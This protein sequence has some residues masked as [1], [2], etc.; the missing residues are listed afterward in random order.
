MIDSVP[1]PESP[2]SGLMIDT[3]PLPESP[4]SGL[5]IGTG[6]DQQKKGTTI[7]ISTVPLPER[8]ILP[9]VY[10]IS[11]LLSRELV[12]KLTDGMPRFKYVEGIRGGI[13]TAHLHLKDEVVLLNPDRFRILASEIA[14]QIGKELSE[15]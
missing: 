1:L 3:V 4:A 5:M 13:R 10:P 6:P 2:A 7:M 9:G 14:T 8:P 11:K 15:V 12:V